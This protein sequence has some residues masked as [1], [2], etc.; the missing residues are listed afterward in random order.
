MFTRLLSAAALTLS[1]FAAPALAHESPDHDAFDYEETKAKYSVRDYVFSDLPE[2]GYNYFK[3]AEDT[4]FVH[5]EFENMVFFVTDDGVVVVDPKPDISPF[6]LEV[7]PMVT[8]KPITHV[9]YSH[10]HRDHSQGAV[11]FPDDAILIAERETA[12][13]LEAA[14]DPKR[15]LP[16]IVFDDD[17]VLETGGLRLE[18][19]DLGRNW[20]SQ[21]DIVIWAPEQK[22]L[23]TVDMF[24]PDAAPWIHWGESSDPWFAYGMPDRLLEAY[25]F[26]FVIVGHERIV[27]TQEHMKTY[28]AFIADMKK[29]MMGVVQSEWY[30]SAAKEA[31]SRIT[32]SAQHYF[33]KANIMTA[34][35]ACADEMIEKWQGRVRNAELNM[36]ENCQT[37]FMHLVIL[38]P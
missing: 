12:D 37:M 27:G 25:D 6:V 5:G 30:Q 38:D 2:R 8:E 29:T 14:N 20:H 32:P 23:F 34:A 28:Q 33:Y 7:I 24:H 31:R 9:I 3:V 11:L 19:K 21:D 13:L 26:N 17:Y 36:V 18:M 16:D 10:H 35:N 15:P 1:L 22:I 4:W